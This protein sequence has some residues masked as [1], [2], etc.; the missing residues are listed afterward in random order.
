MQETYA[1]QIFYTYICVFSVVLGYKNLIIQK[2]C[3]YFLWDLVRLFSIQIQGYLC[4]MLSKC[5][6]DRLCIGP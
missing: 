2:I 1:I 6:T 3:N 5:F 4:I